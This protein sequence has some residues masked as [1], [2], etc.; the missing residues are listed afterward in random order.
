ML[1]PGQLR[2]QGLVG[3]HQLRELPGHPRDLPIPRRELPGLLG[4]L[5][6][7][8]VHD[9]EQL[10]AR[11]RLRPGHRKIEPQTSRSI[12]QRHASNI[13]HPSISART[14]ISH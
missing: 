11:H 1:Q 3:L 13:R 6:G 12:A 4:Q 7:L 14:P 8:A 10:V 2:G 5:P 9:D